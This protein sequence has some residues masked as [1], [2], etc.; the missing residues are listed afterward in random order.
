MLSGLRACCMAVLGCLA[1]TPVH[2]ED[3]GLVARGEYLARAADCVACH[4]APG[5]R[6]FAGGRAITLPFGTIYSPNITPDT[7]HGIG[8]YTDDQFVR[9]MQ[10]GVGRDGRHLYPAF[11]YVAYTLMPREDILAIKAYLFSRPAVAGAP[12]DNQVQFPFDQRWGLWAWN[13]LFNPGHRFRPDP[14]RSA[15]W[16]RGA[17]LVQGPGHCAQCHSPRNIA[18][19][20]DD[21][22]A[23]AG[24]VAQG[25]RAYNLTADSVSG[26]GSW[27][28]SQ[29]ATYLATGHAD[30][31]SAA[32]GPMAEVV[33][34]SLRYLSADD[35][36]AMVTYLRSV[37]P[38]RNAPAVAPGQPAALAGGD[39]IE[40]ER[41][42]ASEC[43][44]CHAWN[45]SG[46][47][48]GNAALLGNRTVNDPAGTNLVRVLL[49]GARLRNGTGAIVYM[50]PFGR[51]HD[52]AQLAAVATYVNHRFGNGTLL[53]KA[54]DV[55]AIRRPAA[56]S[57]PRLLLYGAPAA[58]L[59]ALLL[60][61]WAATAVV[62]R[63]RIAA[64][65]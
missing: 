61:G 20:V 64:S 57:I 31:H 44:N 38:I 36:R 23:F 43:S 25:W 58:A 5:G 46:V 59:A 22:N 10:D 17:Y 34:N 3:A 41:L 47:Q 37:G 8:G 15:E 2:A 9:A 53:L 11:P 7:E 52:D 33:E 45:G 51:L 13:A 24:A 56:T 65:A 1:T 39:A 21:A 19:A 50:P 27:T 60:V 12:P 48:S 49:E 62:R 42:F 16:N 30:G 40:G 54:A 4:S 18:F 29:L 6:P 28:D 32:A 35:L 14:A 26:L 55:A 63:S